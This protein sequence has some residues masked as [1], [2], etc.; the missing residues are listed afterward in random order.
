VDADNSL[1]GLCGFSVLD[2]KLPLF[3]TSGYHHGS[4][5]CY[6]T[7]GLFALF[8]PSRAALGGTPVFFGSLILVFMYLAMTEVAGRKA[9]AVA[10]P[11]LVL[12]P[13]EFW[14][15]TY[16]AWG[17]YVEMTALSAA[18]IWL[19]LRLLKDDSSDLTLGA[20]LYGTVVGLAAWCTPQSL[21]VSVPMTILL[22]R[23]R[24]SLRAGAAACAG[25][26]TGVVPYLISFLQ[27]DVN[28]LSTTYTRPVVGFHQLI[29]NFDY[30][31]MVNVPTLLF[32]LGAADLASSPRALI[33]AVLLVSI[34]VLALA[35]SWSRSRRA[36]HNGAAWLPLL[37]LICS[38][39]FFTASSAGS[40]RLWTV[41]YVVQLYLLVP[42]V[43]AMVYV[44]AS[45]RALRNA[46]AT[47]ALALSILNGFDYPFVNG[48]RE[49]EKGQFQ[50]QQKAI[51]WAEN[52]H[53]DA[54]IG[55]YFTI[56]SWNLDSNRRIR[57]VPFED[58]F[59]YFHFGEGIRH[60]EVRVGLV[61]R[62]KQRLLSWMHNAHL[63]GQIAGFGDN[64]FVAAI[65]GMV[66]GSILHD[67]G[68]ASSETRED[69]SP[70]KPPALGAAQTVDD[71]SDCAVD[72]INGVSAATVSTS[73][74]P[75]NHQSSL[76]IT[77]WAAAGKDGIVP[78]E[79]YVNLRSGDTSF[80]AH[81][82]TLFDR[83]DVAQALH[84]PSLLRSGYRLVG[85]PV[86][87]GTYK[88][89]ILQR[90]QNRVRQCAAVFQV[91]VH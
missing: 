34:V 15:A 43:F 1:V 82:Q 5:G 9:A 47:G 88:L 7:A 78:D 11:L 16:P 91:V 80:F 71:K 25:A 19:G 76:Y 70:S 62:D 38:A 87:A 40:I 61:E 59:D 73:A 14:W 24:W 39:G 17:A 60:R 48:V 18:T 58:E 63:S 33:Q 42:L 66:A 36:Y 4:I 27:G 22:L 52:H 79:V 23:R 29:S 44:R 3:L 26:M 69:F 13:L 32:S 64:L 84:K 20:L 30:F 46:V 6:T 28:P 72:L 8:G 37:V 54:V 57:A 12:P 83:P 75:V 89:T 81:A 53:L 35:I 65:D 55:N 90:N 77:G 41:R 74:S 31:A 50:Q 2:G 68:A 45:S 10:L 21:T 85:G 56:Y 86:P 51:S 49:R 67:L